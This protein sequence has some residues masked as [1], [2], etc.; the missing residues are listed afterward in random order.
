MTH[1]S[2]LISAALAAAVVG[3]FAGQASAG[4]GQT[5]TG[6]ACD[7][8]APAASV[9][10]V[11]AA[12]ALTLDPVHVMDVETAADTD[13]GWYASV[14]GGYTFPDDAEV[15]GFDVPLD[16]GFSIVG[17]VGTNVGAFRVEGEAGYRV[18]D[19]DVTGASGDISAISVMG[20]ALYDHPLTDAL[21][22]Y[23]G[24]GVG[25]AFVDVEDGDESDDDTVLAYQFLVGLAFYTSDNFAITGGYRLWTTSDLDLSGVDVDVPL[26]HTAEIGVRFEF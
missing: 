19:V 26:F 11:P 17:A 4:S 1:P 25:V 13:T 8:T 24:G 5:C 23:V 18:N 6:G 7:S 22:L 12:D 2:K 15:E 10:T 14:M 21:D 3:M 16:E 9:A 20:N